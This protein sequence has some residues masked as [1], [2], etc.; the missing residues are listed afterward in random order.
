MAD[1]NMVWN[2]T[3]DKITERMVISPDDAWDVPGPGRRPMPDRSRKSEYT[4]FTLD[5]RFDTSD[6]D[7]A[8]LKSFMEEYGLKEEELK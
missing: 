6:V 2:I 4:K 7:G 8:W 5:G 1:D 3:R